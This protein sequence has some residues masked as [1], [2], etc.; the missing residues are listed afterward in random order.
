MKVIFLTDVKGKGKRGEVKEM[1]NG[2]AQNFLIKQNLAVE[3]TPESIRMLEMENKQAEEKEKELFEEMKVLAKKLEGVEVVFSLKTDAKSGKVFG[4]V[5]NKQV[6]KELD[7]L[8]YKLDSH[9][10]SLDHAINTLGYTDVEV[11]VY[12]NIKATIKVKV[13]ST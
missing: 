7:K 9:A 13:V 5:S 8:G 6:K 3:A 2:Y 11:K 10:V 1:S 4:S 12:K